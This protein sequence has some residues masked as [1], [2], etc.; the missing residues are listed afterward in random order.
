MSTHNTITSPNASRFRDSRLPFDPRDVVLAHLRHLHLKL[1]HAGVF[2]AQTLV[3]ESALLDSM[4]LLELVAV[5]EAAAG[6]E[7]D[8]LR[9]DPTAV[10][11][12]DDLIAQLQSALQA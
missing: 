9:F 7:L 6:A 8:M 11:T 3:F 5:V 10:S 4:A 2:S 1:G 12:V